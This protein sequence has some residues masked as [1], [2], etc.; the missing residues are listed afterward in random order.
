[1]RAPQG[2]DNFEFEMIRDFV[3][4]DSTI[5]PT[6]D[7]KTDG[8]L[9]RGSQ[10]VY[11][12]L[13]GTIATR[14]GLKLRGLADATTAGTKAS[15]EWTT[16]DGRTLPVRINNNKFQ[17]ESD[18]VATGSYVWYTLLSGLATSFNRSIFDAIWDTT[19]SKDSLVFVGGS[20][21]LYS[22]SG[23]AAL[24]VS[25]TV[26]TIVL[27]RNATTAG[28]STSGS[29]IIN[30]NTYTYTG[31]SGS[32][33]TGS[34]NASAEAANSAVF[35]TTIANSNTPASGFTNDFLKVISNQLYVG[36]YTSRAI[37][38]SKNSG[39]SNWTSYSQSNP[40][41]TG[42][43]GIVYL[44]NTAKGVGIRNGN[45]W[46][47]SGTSDWW[48]VS[49]A[50]ISNNNILTEQIKQIKKP[51]SIN[52]APLGHEFIDNIGD[53]LI[54]LC[55]D[56][57]VRI[58]GQFADHFTTRYPTLSL[59]MKTEF[60][61]TDF[62]G[63]HLRCIGN[64]I[65]LTAPL[66]G[67]DYMHETREV[68][69]SANNI[70]VEKFWHPPQVRNISRFAVIAGVTYG[71]S[72]AYPQLYKVWSTGQWY[73][74]DPNGAQLP[75][76]CTLLLKYRDHGR[77]QGKISF[78]KIFTE[79]YAT[80]NSN[81]QG[82]AYYDYQGSEA[83]LTFDINT[84]SSPFRKTFSGSQ[85]PSLGD[86]SLGDNPL[87]SG[88]VTTV[89]DQATLPKWK[90]INGMSST[91]CYEYALMLFSQSAGARWELLAIGTNA[92]I[93]AFQGIELTKNQ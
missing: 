81:I 60:S 48:E 12:R 91:D 63:G 14:P 19:T 79:G 68:I 72:N 74:D 66:S 11:K 3:G 27:D 34:Q 20:S 44:D 10:N 33:L 62:T 82:A 64:L 42:E 87:G 78:D 46:I 29:V 85:P 24:F 30:G 31:I 41:L 57:Q 84:T 38:F 51:T 16:W 59:E 55:Q 25:G 8:I 73:D 7:T 45:A 26:N 9:V 52:S 35:E 61:E 56:N 86:A 90:Q 89:G 70:V 69:G 13:S 37:Y 5:D 1:M 76:T 53:E 49:F 28:F 39:A 67:F 47:G 2:T 23:G 50:Q 88:L 6:K 83:L 32:T 15:W 17:V 21:S 54:C 71:H 65:Q 58:I 75:Y 22:W 80:A 4:Y 43:G 93:S 77:R 36:S 40:R 18:I 92:K